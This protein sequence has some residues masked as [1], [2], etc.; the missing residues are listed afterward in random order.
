M[1]LRINRVRINRARPVDTLYLQKQRCKFSF[2]SVRSDRGVCWSNRPPLNFPFFKLEASDDLV[3]SSS[4]S[5]DV[6]DDS[7]D[8]EEFGKFGSL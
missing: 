8:D 4:G 7:E 2:R 5:D 6:E 3:M 1:E